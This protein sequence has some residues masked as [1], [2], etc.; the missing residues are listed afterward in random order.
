MVRSVGFDGTRYF[1]QED[2][3]YEPAVGFRWLVESDAHWSFV[4]SVSPG[5]GG[6][7]GSR[8]SFGGQS[9]NKF[10]GG[11]SFK[12]FQDAAARVEYVEG[13]FYWRVE[14]GEMARATDYVKPPLMLS[15]EV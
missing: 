7:S 11:K 9:F 4:K 1:W 12:M 3:L 5:E 10:Y 2:L 6:E 15:K 14:A 8:A 13:E